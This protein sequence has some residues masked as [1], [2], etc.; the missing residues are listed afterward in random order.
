[1][2]RKD[3]KVLEQI[4]R[5]QFEEEY[6]DYIYGWKRLSRIA[7]ILMVVSWLMFGAL[8]V[9]FIKFDSIYL[10]EK[11]LIVLVIVISVVM[12]IGLFL[13][14][15]VTKSYVAEWRDFRDQCFREQREKSEREQ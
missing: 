13:E 14:H 2:R 8:A 12:L 9:W 4:Y 5:R 10:S 6:K 3:R 15:M 11:W 1:M 7:W